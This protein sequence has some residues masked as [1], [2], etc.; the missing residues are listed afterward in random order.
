MTCPTCAKLDTLREF[1]YTTVMKRPILGAVLAVVAFSLLACAKAKP[2]NGIFLQDRSD[3]MISRT[4]RY[5]FRDDGTGVEH[6]LEKAI[7]PTPGTGP[8]EEFQ[9]K[10]TWRYEP[11][12]SKVFVRFDE[13]PNFLWV[14]TFDG[15]RLAGAEPLNVVGAMRLV[16]QE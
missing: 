6:F 12:S 10:F 1:R 11:S 9:N 8:L 16:H 4:D 13:K 7:N 15:I 5:D 2:P 3:S 14:F